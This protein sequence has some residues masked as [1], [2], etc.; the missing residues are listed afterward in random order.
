LI[1]EPALAAA[2]HGKRRLRSR[3]DMA[4]VGARLATRF[5]VRA[6]LRQAA[7]GGGSQ[8]DGLQGERP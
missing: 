3:H 4:V 8:D 6:P 1:Q 2:A 5:R 7:T